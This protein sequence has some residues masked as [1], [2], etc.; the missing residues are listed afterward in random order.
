MDLIL[1]DCY[2]RAPYQN[3]P[4]S[5]SRLGTLY[6]GNYRETRAIRIF[7]LIYIVQKSYFCIG[8]R[9]WVYAMGVRYHCPTSCIYY[10][11][12]L[13]HALCYIVTE[14]R[15]SPGFSIYSRALEL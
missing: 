2:Y 7:L 4:L 15:V 6:G 9:L 12:P 11:I 5:R 14:L 1:P 13:W 10:L 3:Y 8:M